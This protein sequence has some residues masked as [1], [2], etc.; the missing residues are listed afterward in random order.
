M[1]KKIYFNIIVILLICATTFV[2]YSTNEEEINKT[3]QEQAQ[4][5]TNNGNSKQ[6]EEIAGLQEQ[7]SEIQNKAKESQESL[8]ILNIKITENLQQVQKM[9]ETISENQKSLDEANKKISEIVTSA[10]KIQK[11]LNIVTKKYNEQKKLLDQRLVAMYEM[12]DTTYLDYVLTSSS[13]SDF[14]S[15]YYLITEL[16]EYDVNLLETV[17][18][19]KKTIEKNKNQLEEK[20]KNLEE[21]RKIQVKTKIILENSKLIRQNYIA[22][23]SEEEKKA[24]E[25]LDE[26]NRQ[27]AQIESEILSLVSTKSFGES[28]IG[29]QMIWPI[30]GHYNITSPFAMRV[31][32]ITKVYKL[33]TGIDIS[34]QMGTD[35]LASAHGMVVKAEYNSA[36]GNMVIIDHGGGVQ[37]LYA[38]GSSIEVQVGQIVNAGD[39]VIKV[40]ST[41]YSTGPHA[42][43]EIRVNGEPINPLE[44]ISVP[45][46]EKKD[47]NQ[48]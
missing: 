15:T 30:E 14:L 31:H 11:E 44:H 18:R 24:Q 13:L 6:D 48:Q 21:E 12:T 3:E 33:H 29:G 5:Q 16:T 43:F 41:G 10:K 38:H 34:A 35:F 42:H 22:K 25:Q 45:G 40:G 17:D 26:Y 23:L 32:P 20:K 36:Y 46:Q 37:T 4:G 19:E 7:K 27:V 39:V 9:D 8:E 47:N 2:S 1:H 28:Y